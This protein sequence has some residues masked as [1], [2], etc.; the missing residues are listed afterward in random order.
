MKLTAVLYAVF[1]LLV[2]CGPR[3]P[4][5]DC[6]I[7]RDQIARA[8]AFR[9]CNE[10]FGCLLSGKEFASMRYWENEDPQCFAKEVER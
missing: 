9:E 2:G 6:R 1:L 3:D 10:N 5:G 4:Q 7:Y 8:K